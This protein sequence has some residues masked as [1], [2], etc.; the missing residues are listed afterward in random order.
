MTFVAGG[1]WR[2]ILAVLALSILTRPLVWMR[3]RDDCRKA[4]RILDGSEFTE[5]EVRTLRKLLKS[6]LHVVPAS[7]LDD[8][9]WRALLEEAISGELLS[10]DKAHEEV[11]DIALEL[12]KEYYGSVEELVETSLQLVSM[13]DQDAGFR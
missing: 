13:S 7:T 11:L 4:R 5:P 1:W 8:P 3:A 6:N 9:R 12:A 10:D 2:G